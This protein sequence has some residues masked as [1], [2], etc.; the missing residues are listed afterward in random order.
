MFSLFI[1]IHVRGTVSK[2]LEGI[3]LIQFNERNISK[4]VLL[5]HYFRFDSI[6]AIMA[7]ETFIVLRIFTHKYLY[8]TMLHVCLYQENY[9]VSVLVKLTMYPYVL[10]T[11]C[12]Q[13]FHAKKIPYFTNI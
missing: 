6:F 2:M 13:N 3:L 12:V 11:I 10:K 7:L 5:F 9:P 1:S 8:S 4:H